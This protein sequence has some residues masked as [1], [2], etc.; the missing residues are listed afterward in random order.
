MPD[1]APVLTPGLLA[2]L[3][4]CWQRVHA[5]IAAVVKPGIDEAEIDR[6]T[7][8][9]GLTL[10]V[11]ARVWWRELD[12]RLPDRAAGEDAH[13]TGAGWSFMRLD[14]AVRDAIRLREMAAQVAASP[15][16]PPGETT[17]ADGWI[18]ICWID[19]GRLF[20]DCADPTAPVSPVRYVQWV[21][22]P[23]WPPATRSIGELVSWWI[24]A[25]D[26]GGY[27]LDATANPP[28][29]CD[30]DDRLDRRRRGTGVA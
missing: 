16:C 21:A 7:A 17:W 11:E 30:K 29:L 28:M 14:D 9:L 27:Y 23:E 24:E 10:P 6:L 22:M 20:I 18:P 2:A 8:P 12:V 3:R 25:F 5:P 19:H 4:E 1:D 26:T 15:G 13:M